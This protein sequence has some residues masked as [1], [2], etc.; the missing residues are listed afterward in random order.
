MPP[1]ERSSPSA[2]PGATKYHPEWVLANASGGAQLAVAGRVAGGGDGPPAGHARARP[3]LRPGVDVD[4][5]APRVR[6]PGVG[7]RPV[8]QP[9]G[10]H[11]AHP[12]RRRRRRRLPAP[13][14]R[15]F[16]A[17]RRGVLRRHHLHR[18]LLLL[19][20]RRPVPQL[21]RSLRQGRA[22]SS[23]S[24]ARACVRDR[25]RGAGAPAGVVDAGHVVASTSAAWLRRHWERTGL[26]DVESADTMPDGWRL[27]LQWHLT[28]Y[29]DNTD[30]ISGDRGRRRPDD[31]LR[32]G[33]GAA[34][35][36]GAARLLLAG[37]DAVDAEAAVH[38]E[39]AAARSGA[40][41]PP[42]PSS[43]SSPPARRRSSPASPHPAA[44][45]ARAAA[46]PPAH[47]H[48][49]PATAAA[50]PRAEQQQPRRRV[51]LPQPQRL[52]RTHRRRQLEELLDEAEPA[53]R[54]VEITGPGGAG[55]S[56]L[57]KSA[58]EGRHMLSRVLV[59]APD[60]TPPGGW[61]ALRSRVRDRRHSRT[62]SARICPAM[63]A[64]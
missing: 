61:P 43:G 55:K 24:P 25:R 64:D 38:E 1:D 40:N 19:R 23:A 15:P 30:E 47:G 5:P 45:R 57:L 52:G 56:G 49:R 36:R 10:E 46:P 16:A 6:R 60:R 18:L 29:P 59:L 31:R 13:R 63:A 21:P 26:V 34:A 51:V 48:S 12:R 2:F 22:A 62:V 3:G 7:D 44:T 35:R 9:V 41:S 28:G 58:A 14:R 27:W 39:A 37:H 50:P 53:S 54:V 11:P 33:G 17:V 4:L 8:D 42:P 32:P 20:H